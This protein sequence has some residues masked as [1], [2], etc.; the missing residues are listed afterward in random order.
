MAETT[1][2]PAVFAG[3]TKVDVSIYL[4]FIISKE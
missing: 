3:K 1:T 4:N 2:G